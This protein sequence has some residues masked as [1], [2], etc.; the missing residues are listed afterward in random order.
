MT[1]FGLPAP[2]ILGLVAVVG[3]CVGRFL[4]I[5]ILRFPDLLTIKEQGTALLKP[6]AICRHCNKPPQF[7]EKI[8]VVGWLVSHR[9][10]RSCGSLISSHML[11]IEVITALLFVGMYAWEVPMSPGASPL[12]TGLHSVEGPD[13][14][15]V[16]RDLW[17]PTFWM[18]ARYAFHMLMICGLLVA[19][20]IDRRLRII[21]SGSTDPI[22]WASMAICFAAGQLYIVPIWFQDESTV[23]ILKPIVPVFLRPFCVPWDPTQFIQTWP[24]LHG[25]LVSAVGALVGA[26]S[27]WIVRQIGFF[28]LKQEAMGAGDVYLMGMIGSVI[29][30]QPVLAVFMLAPMLGVAVAIGN[31]IANRDNMIPYGPFLS[32]GAVL[33]LLTWPWSWPLAKR[34]FDMGPL[35]IPMAILMVLLLTVSLQLVQL[36][37]RLLGFGGGYADIDDGGWTSAD[38]LAYYNGERPDEQTGNWPTPQ[39]PGSRAGRGLKPYQDWRNS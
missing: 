3:L 19:T 30:W 6:W 13:G 16:I 5:C 1:P 29:G 22:M 26:R 25:F 37:K 38:H 39:W 12:D 18:N 7:I 21:P 35:L 2:V 17:S 32:L 11:F 9:R 34:F 10:C 33:L 8:P 36:G 4:Y 15:E 27:V 14:P 28:V 31:L 24:H 23:R 20:D